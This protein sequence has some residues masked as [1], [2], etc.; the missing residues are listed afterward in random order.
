[1]NEIRDPVYEG[2]ASFAAELVRGGVTD[3][4]ISPWINQQAI[5]GRRA[6]YEKQG[7]VVHRISE[8]E[9]AISHQPSGISQDG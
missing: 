3:V 9:S 1:M 2:I 8:V 5:W 4:V 6:E 7:L